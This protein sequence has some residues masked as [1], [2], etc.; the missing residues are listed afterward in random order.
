MAKAVGAAFSAQVRGKVGGLVYNTWRGTATIKAKSS[1]T[2]PQT[3]KQLALRAIAV[4]CARKWGSL[5]TQTLWND[6]AANHPLVDWT[7][8]PKRLTG[9]N[10]YV[11]L[12]TRLL[13]ASTVPPSTPPEAPAPDPVFGLTA[14]GASGSISVDWDAPVG[15][16][17][18][19]ELWLTGPMTA[20]RLPSLVNARYNTLLYGSGSPATV[21]AAQAGCYTVYA[22]VFSMTTGLVSSYTAASCVVT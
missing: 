5:A 21:V 15:A 18:R 11:M 3:V 1:P 22:R 13:R 4:Y 12:G 8:S 17:D 2:Q 6:Y 10:W 19:I 9:M 16:N 14:T 7:N 20:G